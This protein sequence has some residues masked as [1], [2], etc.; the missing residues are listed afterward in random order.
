MSGR[1]KKRLL[2]FAFVALVVDFVTWDQSS[3]SR[4]LP[5]L[6]D[7]A[8]EGI[9]SI[10]EDRGPALMGRRGQVIDAFLATGKNDIMVPSFPPDI[11]YQGVERTRY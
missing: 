4:K 7:R 6:A 8:L 2:G 5:F 11:S 10:V 1:S 3:A 9:A